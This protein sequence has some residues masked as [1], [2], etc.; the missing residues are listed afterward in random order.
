M[1]GKL[2]LSALAAC[3]L[4]GAQTATTLKAAAAPR[5]FGAAI[6]ERHLSNATDTKFT[7]LAQMHFSAA[8]PENE[9]KWQARSAKITA[10]F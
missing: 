8:T 2:L 4:V 3:S 7:E 6:S 1:S 9:M 5:V 10:G